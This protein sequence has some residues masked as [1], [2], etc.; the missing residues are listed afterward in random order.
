[1]KTTHDPEALEA[2]FQEIAELT[3]NHDV[4]KDYACVLASRLGA[5]LEKVDFE[6]W[7]QETE[8]H[9]KLKTPRKK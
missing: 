3:S 4:I 9:H 6:W 1:M 7:R 5:A 8:I 2:F